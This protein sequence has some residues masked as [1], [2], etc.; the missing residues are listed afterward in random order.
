MFLAI[1][2]F[3]VALVLD[4]TDGK[5]SVELRL[6]VKFFDGLIDS[7]MQVAYRW[8]ND[9]INISIQMRTF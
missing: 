4:C 2:V 8:C 9:R 7:I 1:A 5:L 6:I 3:F